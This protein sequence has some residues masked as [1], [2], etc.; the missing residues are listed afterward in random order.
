MQ[1]VML[2]EDVTDV[3]D[4]KQG[5]MLSEHLP[6]CGCGRTTYGPANT[7]DHAATA[8]SAP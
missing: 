8:P 5:K 7:G 4:N 2:W 6:L 1:A 3:M